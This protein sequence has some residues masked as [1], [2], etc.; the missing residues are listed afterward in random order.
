MFTIAIISFREFLEAILIVSVFL[1]VSKKLRLKKELEILL[2]AG[3]GIALSFCLTIATYFFGSHAGAIFTEKNADFLESYLLI[4]SGFFIAYV[5]FSLHK[6]IG[7]NREK[8][9]HSAHA[10]L[11]QNDFDISLFLTIIFLV[12]REGFE[13]ALFSASISLFS[14][15]IQNLLGLV[16]GFSAAAVI[17]SLTFF[18]YVKFP[19]KKVFKAT[20]YVIIL[21]GA[22]LAQNGITKLLET[23]FNISLANM[24]S[25]PVLMFDSPG[26][27]RIR[28][29]IPGILPWPL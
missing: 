24:I 10:K 23:H 14:A 12:V 7:K 17:G 2:A 4:F 1:G 9:M 6:T 25:F 11:E 22:S 18:A 15:F 13:V 5:V 28:Q 19:I 21:L 26:I 29:A 8:I 27:C 20:E 16:I 3:I